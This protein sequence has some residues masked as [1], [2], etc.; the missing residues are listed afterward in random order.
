MRGLLRV[1]FCNGYS[2]A[3]D[4]DSLDVA[5]ILTEIAR[6]DRSIAA[7]CLQH[8]CRFLLL[9]DNVLVRTRKQLRE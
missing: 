1:N 5:V 6:D 9:L 4:D 2:F 8:C 7:T 3:H